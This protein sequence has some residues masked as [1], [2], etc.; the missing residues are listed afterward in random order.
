MDVWTAYREGQ[1]GSAPRPFLGF[2]LLLEDC[3]R[4]H[5]PVKTVEA[6]FPVDEQFRGTSYAKRYEIL[7]RRLVL[8]RNYDAVCMAL[9][10]NEVP[11]SISQPADDLNFERFTKT[12]Q[13]SVSRFF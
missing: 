6:N 9:A 2:F 5:K 10:T 1:F 3:T 11:S 13:A 12:L 8:E 4:V 7:C